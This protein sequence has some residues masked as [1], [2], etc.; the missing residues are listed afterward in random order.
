MSRPNELEA[1]FNLT[2]MTGSTT[3]APWN[4]TALYVN[5][6]TRNFSYGGKDPG[7]VWY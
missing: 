1:E 4:I 2:S 7:S 5:T 6:S 3:S